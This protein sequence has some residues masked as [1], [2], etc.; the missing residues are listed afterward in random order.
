MAS[1]NKFQDFT[2]QLIRGTHDWDAHNFKVALTN[3]APL[4]AQ[5]SWSASN[6]PPPAFTD[7]YP[8]GG[9]STVITVSETGGVTTVSG[10]QCVFS[11]SGGSIGP[12]RYAILYNDTATNPAD[13]AVG[14]WDYGN[15]ITLGDGETFTLRFS[16][17]SPGVIFTLA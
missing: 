14:W 11:A 15:S 9:L 7:G 13:A 5:A 6:H 2:E 10:V 8:S 12:F 17:A 3:T 1:F 4:A 16:N